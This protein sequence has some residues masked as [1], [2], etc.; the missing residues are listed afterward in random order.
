M[1]TGGQKTK[2]MASALICFEQ[3]GKDG[4]EFLSGSC[5]RQ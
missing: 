1:P 3:Y 5:N 2:R 4:D